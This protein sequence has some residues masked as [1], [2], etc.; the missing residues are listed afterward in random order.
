MR[1][2]NLTSSNLLSCP[3]HA[4]VGVNGRNFKKSLVIQSLLLLMPFCQSI[5]VA[6]KFLKSPLELNLTIKSSI[7]MVP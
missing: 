3:S 4:I 2:K 5:R 6:F 7:T 1:C